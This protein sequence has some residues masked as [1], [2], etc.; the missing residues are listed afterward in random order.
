MKTIVRLFLLCFLSALMVS[1]Q[2]GLRTV[3]PPEKL[4]FCA[5]AINDNGESC[6]T[7]TWTGDHYAVDGSKDELDS[8]AITQWSGGKVVMRRYFRM[9]DG[10]HTSLMGTNIN[11]QLWMDCTARIAPS[12]DHTEA[13]TLK[14]PMNEGTCRFTWDPR[15]SS[16]EIANVVAVQIQAA[17]REAQIQAHIKAIA[18]A[19]PEHRVNGILVPAGASDVFA[20]YPAD[21]RAILRQENPLTEDPMTPCDSSKEDDTGTGVNDPVAALEI[22]KFAL[23]RGENERGEC[24]IN[25]SGYLDKNPRAVVLIGVCFLMGWGLPQDAKRAFRYFDGEWAENHDAWAMYFAEQGYINGNGVAKNISRA[26][27]IDGSLM[28]SDAGREIFSLIGSDDENWMRRAQNI[29]EVMNPDTKTVTRC[30]ST[31]PDS[32][33]PGA[34]KNQRCEEATVNK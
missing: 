18:A 1:A 13:G 28:M 9:D 6:E 33:V 24:W 22:G 17:A 29:R 23:R 15:S 7:D 32:T 16:R 31:G 20:S 10:T 34:P 8:F 11:P 14:G 26:G 27:Q 21:I 12:G 25:H 2:S 19:S 5:S 3:Y 30:Y 4:R